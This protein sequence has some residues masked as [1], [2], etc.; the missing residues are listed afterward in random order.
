MGANQYMERRSDEGLKNGG[1]RAHRKEV[2]ENSTKRERL[3]FIVLCRVSSRRHWRTMWILG[4]K[5]TP[6]PEHTKMRNPTAQ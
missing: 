5:Q 2:S 1:E 4:Y 6:H 3:E